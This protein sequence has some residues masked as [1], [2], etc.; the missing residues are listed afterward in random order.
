VSSFSYGA[1]PAYCPMGT[2]GPFPGV[3]RGGA[4]C[5]PLTPSSAEVENEEELYMLSPCSSIGVLWDSF[6]FH[7]VTLLY[8][9]MYLLIPLRLYYNV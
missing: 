7:F 6:T 4:W 3:K 2:M 9:T 5:W 8:N 1:H